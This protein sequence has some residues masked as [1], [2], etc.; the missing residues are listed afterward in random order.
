[1]KPT[2][3]VD[4]LLAQA[5]ARWRAGQPPAPE[6][7]LQ[8]ITG[9]RKPK[10]REPKRWV[11]V[12]A[13][14][15]VAAIAT[16]ALIVLPGNGDHETVAPSNETPPREH[17][18]QVRAGDKVQVTGQVVAAPGAPVYYC[19]PVPTV[20]LPEG[21]PRPPAC[22]PGQ[23]I[24]VTGVDVARLTGLETILG[25]KTGRAHLVGIWSG[26]K[27]SVEQQSPPPRGP[28]AP[29]KVPCSPP[30]G[31]WKP[32][33]AA[34][35][36]TPAVDAFIK[37]RPGELQA[38]WISW[39]EGSPTD[40]TPGAPPNKPSVLMIGVAHGDLDQIRT[41]IDPLVAGNLCVTKVRFSQ[42]EIN[43]LRAAVAALPLDDLDL[44][45]LGVGTRIGDT[46]VTISLR[47]VD[48]KVVDAFRSIGLD[49]LDFNP[50]IKPAN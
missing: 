47:I 48:E 36:I 2:D 44:D 26:G 27:I 42:T 22:L 17:P 28:G 33:Y 7:D 13:A 14:A 46:P 40:A 49:K 16:A 30:A 50:V 32:A 4:D 3:E 10:W 29:E 38:P 11:P 15:S 5:G 9:P 21:K 19:I 43:Q 37:A 45:I 6:P 20:G 39:P 1:M 24:E 34:D 12:L 31:G 23:Q 41:A 8:R 18:M 25:V 35:S